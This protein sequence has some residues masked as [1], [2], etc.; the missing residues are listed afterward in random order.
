[1][2]HTCLP[3]QQGAAA[4]EAT[5]VPLAGF[6]PHVRRWLSEAFASPS[7]AQQLA[8][9]AIRGGESTLL[10]APTGS[11]KTLAAF[12]CA[13]DRL[14]RLAESGQL[15]D[16]THVL[17]VTPLKALGN[18]IYRNLTVPLAGIRELAGAGLPEV[19][20]AIR[21]G[22]TPQAERERM[23]R[24]PPHILITTP[25]SLFLL[26][27]TPRTRDL[28]RTVRT[29]IV[30]EVH[31]LCNGKR[32]VHLAVSLERLQRLVSAPLQ[33]VGCSA[34]LRPLDRLA[35]FLV[36]YDA[37]G[38]PRPCTAIDAGTRK[39]LDLQVLTPLP[40][41]VEAADSVL[42]S[43][44]YE[45]ILDHIG[46]HDTTLVFANSRYKAERTALRLT[47]LAGDSARVSVHHGSVSKERRLQTEDDLK[48]GRL[49]AVVATTSLELGIDIGSV[50]LVL[51]LESPRS[52]ATGLQ[53]VGRAGHLLD[54][55]SKGRILVF[56]R[57]DLVEAAAI[58]RAMSA[59]EVD[60]IDIPT[61]CLDVLA[62]QIA[63]CASAEAMQ[64]D[65]LYA[66]CRQAYP[67][68][69]LGRE[70]FDSVLG[71][72]AGEFP[73]DAARPPRAHLIWDRA[74][75]LVTG[76]RGT[77]SVCAQCVGTIAESSEYDVTIA[78]SKRRVGSVHSEFVEDHLHRGDVFVLGS[79]AWRVVGTERG[80]L[81]VEE[82]PGS[83]PTVPWW[84]GPIESRTPEVGRRVGELR[85]VVAGG[86][87][88]PL[89][90]ERLCAD[91]SLAPEAAA[92]VVA[93]VREQHAAAGI[94]P[95]H[96]SLL[97]ETWRD[98]LGR[99]YVLVHSPFGER[100]N[101]T[102]GMALARSA[103][104][105]RGEQ[106]S[107]TATN[108]LLMLGAPQAASADA[109]P[110][111][112]RELMALV[113]SASLREAAVASS[114]T[115]LGSG[116]AFREA[117]VVS[118]Q[119]LRSA[120]GG[121][122]PLWLQNY[123]AQELHEV[124][125]DSVGYPVNAEVVRGYVDEV[126]DVPAL[127]ELLSRIERGEAR[128][129]F[130]MAECPSPFAHS[131]LLRGAD[132]SAAAGGR[133]RRAQLLRLHRRLLEEVLTSEE[134]ADLLDP[135][136]IGEV[137]GRLQHTRPGRRARDSEE[138]WEI[139]RRLGGL[140]AAPDALASVCEAPPCGLLEPLVGS[141]RVVALES[142]GGDGS[143]PLLVVTEQ[144]AE[145][146]AALGHSEPD[147]G[148]TVLV[149]EMADGRIAGF[150]SEPA[151]RKLG[152]VA[153]WRGSR[154]D[155]EVAV[156]ERFLRCR[157]PITVYDVAE[158][159][160]WAPGEAEALLTE[161]EE[162]G[163]VVRGIF[164]G[165]KPRPQWVNKANLEEIHRLSLR[166]LRHELSACAAV[167]VVDFMTRWQHVHPSTRLS[168]EDG[169][170]EVIR[171]LQ[172]YE[173]I[174]GA[175]E[176]EVLPSRVADYRPEM[177][178]RL[179]G[180]GEICWRRLGTKGIR[181]GFISLCL[182]ADVPWL[183]RGTVVSFAG[184]ETA[185]ED[186]AEEIRAVRELVRDRRTVRFDQ[187]VAA[188]GLDPGI[189][190]RALWH[191][192][193]CGEAYCDTYECLRYAEFQTSLSACYDL[194]S[195][196]R[197]IVNGRVPASRV[198]K[199]MSRRRLDA[200]IGRWHATE[201]LLPE[202]DPVDPSELTRRWARQ[203]LARWGIVTRDLLQQEVAAPQWSELAP[204]LK[205]LELLGQ[206]RR[207]YFIDGHHG[208]QY[209]L[210]EAVELLRECR[211]RRGDGT[212]LG[213]LEG[214]PVLALT[215]RDPANLYATCL[216]ITDGRGEVF[217]R[218]MKH[219]N[220]T[221]RA[222]VQA[223]QVLI[224]LP[225]HQLV[226]L[227]R[228]QLEACVRSLMY[229]CAGNAV[230]LGVGQWN[231]GPVEAVPV[232]GLLHSMG[233]A[234]DAH[235]WMCWPPPRAARPAPGVPAHTAGVFEPYYGDDAGTAA[236]IDWP[237]RRAAE[238]LKAPIR[239]YLHG[240]QRAAEALEWDFEW[241]GYGCRAALGRHARLDAYVARS[242]CDASVR[243]R[244]AR[245]P[246]APPV[247]RWRARAL[248][249]QNTDPEAALEQARAAL[250]RATELVVQHDRAFAAPSQ[251][252]P[253]TA[254]Q[255]ELPM[256]DD[257]VLINRAPVLTLWAAVVARQMGYEWDTA[258][259]L[260][261]VVSGLN[262]QAKGR[263]LGIYSSP[264][265]KEP[266][267]TGEPK[268]VGLG[269]DFWVRVCGR[270]IPA[271]NTD[272]GVRGVVG[273]D[274]VD[275]R[276]VEKYLESKFGEDLATVRA[277]MEALAASR[278]HQELED[279]SYDLY[280]AFRPAVERGE[281]GWGQKGKLDLGLIR[282]LSERRE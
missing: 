279:T 156:L 64:A 38:G 155:A 36:G 120:Q 96:E 176:S 61:G 168:G 75:G 159:T 106:W 258:L 161:L 105:T 236:S 138:L 91:Y 154:R 113:S 163:T 266:E 16:Q 17:Y 29:V 83:T 177:L 242:Y 118:L 220:L 204:E 244:L 127:T 208:E 25:E 240:L 239:A 184:A 48:S 210:P 278:T 99:W 102:W 233:F 205:R 158:R 217:H 245:G 202:L 130:R 261:K 15:T 82:A 229:D 74:M 45:R 8:W 21:T 100:V 193:W 71:M 109:P 264:K 230:S 143:P 18:D 256:S 247:F 139:M 150:V 231:G 43:A 72:M 141:G 181:R 53:R 122:V 125:R 179:M 263:S 123:R 260:G 104:A 190:T 39:S 7:P 47:E 136:A 237:I 273:P 13:I 174:Q 11:G 222:A 262:A 149:P 107:V 108:D 19:R 146:R 35:A 4:W 56:D 219:G 186:I 165:T 232:C 238:A 62:Q 80:R 46:E 246:D 2:A 265:E 30:D 162:S 178:D 199:Q 137:E 268:K 171:Q 121:R 249:L 192:A 34:T 79:S 175:L 183:S 157:G 144:W 148:R 63:G 119:V 254:E 142:P 271:K 211:G 3:S 57:D 250:A 32:G 65:D 218:R 270:P 92:A 73:F 252:R 147:R 54:A 248:T 216:E 87:G 277:A 50:N 28:L 114:R 275:P 66:L 1:M 59:G 42:W 101:R 22:D 173:L 170:R 67:Y 14:Q 187:V 110:P 132:P 86:L 209:G 70:E 185:D 10:L 206:A 58:C 97:I 84:H 98:E 259:S 224:Y 89:L 81:L 49:D 253:L 267:R 129:V 223:G 195:T 124:S 40:D 77:A 41:L 221:H 26:L 31:A 133:E 93:Y 68:A 117:A 251:P 227:E 203:L 182:E 24:R 60:A 172:G 115:A 27:G 111:D 94:V 235:G 134:M 194:D 51:Q 90:F 213:W 188:S 95:D 6:S 243:A 103:E 225:S 140:P 37:D 200:R 23:I 145:T 197:K 135:R 9:P 152:A 228:E 207:G 153:R 5:R 255:E 69:Q 126:L 241:K 131:L 160:A 196:P 274:P 167:D 212:V 116:T 52:V 269:E 85:R 88:D 215:N 151:A 272:E 257:I 33:R 281:R 78:A 276:K 12:L 191:L 166:Y 112:A 198:L 180:L 76:R 280:E 55:T 214:E 226:P 234:P 44:A 201:R 282:S 128:L 20:A 169:L 189:V 164:T